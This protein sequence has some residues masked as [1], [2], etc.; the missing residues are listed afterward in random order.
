M[1]KMGVK[2]SRL[3][4]SQGKLARLETLSKSFV[5]SVM[6]QIQKSTRTQSPQNIRISSE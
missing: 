6:R 3:V 2:W 4:Y 1:D 5:K